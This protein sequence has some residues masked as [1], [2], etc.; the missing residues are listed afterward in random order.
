MQE[1]ETFDLPQKFTRTITGMFGE[2][3]K[4]WLTRLPEIVSETAANWSLKFEGPFKN[5]SYHF[6]APCRRADGSRAVLKV[7]FP[8]EELEFFNEVKTLRFYNGHGAVRLLDVDEARF[9]MLLEKLTPG[10]SLGKIC[11]L[12]AARAVKIA[13]GILKALVREI[14]PG[15]LRDAAEYQRLENWIAG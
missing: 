9:A 10:E 1:H 8:G 2:S 11:L 5:L 3:G 7:G 15:E 13:A 14:P 12:D 4:K 6:V